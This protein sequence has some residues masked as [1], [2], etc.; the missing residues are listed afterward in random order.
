[1]SS[2]EGPWVAGIDSSTQSCK[3]V[4]CEVETGRVVRAG[5]A[6]HPP[7]TEVSASAWLQALEEVGAAPGFWDTRSIRRLARRQ[8]PRA[9]EITFLVR[10]HGRDAKFRLPIGFEMA[11]SFRADRRPQRRPHVLQH[12]RLQPHVPS[13]AKIYGATLAPAATAHT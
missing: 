12:L 1:M 2:G 9:D 7:G 6:A 5:R 13:P 8:F 10:L 3:I 4:I 11:K